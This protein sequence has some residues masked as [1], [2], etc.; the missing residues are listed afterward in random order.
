MNFWLLNPD[1]KPSLVSP[2]GSWMCCTDWLTSTVIN[3]WPEI[4]KPLNLPTLEPSSSQGTDTKSR[5]KY[6]TSI[7]GFTS[8]E[9]KPLCRKPCHQLLL[10][11]YFF[12]WEWKGIFTAVSLLSMMCH[13]N[14]GKNAP[15]Y[16]PLPISH[17][18][19]PSP[20]WCTCQ[21]S[22]MC[23]TALLTGVKYESN[24]GQILPAGWPVTSKSLLF[25][26]DLIWERWGTC[27][28]F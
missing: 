6:W 20:K 10:Y 28:G 5:K 15:T 18:S 24:R 4:L 3:V 1:G 26:A 2:K 25:T 12:I 19:P 21:I 16:V 17:P 13:L 23:V 11:F 27:L 9:Q 22:R 7:L 14:L 8:R